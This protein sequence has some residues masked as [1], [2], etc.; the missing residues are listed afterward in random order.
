MIGGAMLLLNPRADTDSLYKINPTLQCGHLKKYNQVR[1]DIDPLLRNKI[2]ITSL[3]SPS[4]QPS[5]ERR[6]R[7]IEAHFYLQIKSFQCRILRIRKA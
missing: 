2:M 1:N 3:L 4:R 7:I 6:K 5:S